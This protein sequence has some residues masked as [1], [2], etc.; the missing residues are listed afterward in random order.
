MR[1][2][3]LLSK[4]VEMLLSALLLLGKPVGRFVATV[5]LTVPHHGA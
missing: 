1:D 4:L 2:E 3:V 5:H